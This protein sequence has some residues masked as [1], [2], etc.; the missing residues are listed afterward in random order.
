M[1]WFLLIFC[2]A[3]LGLGVLVDWWNKKHGLHDFD[4]EVN[5][6]HVSESER[7][8]IESYMHNLKNDH[9]DGPF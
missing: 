2:L 4:P 9:T 6:K 1:M 8:Y 3:L 5:E 7:A